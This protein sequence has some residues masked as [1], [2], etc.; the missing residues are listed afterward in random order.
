M[1][2]PD[3]CGHHAVA[4]TFSATVLSL[5]RLGTGSGSPA[6][7][8]PVFSAPDSHF[9]GPIHLP[10]PWIFRPTGKRRTRRDQQT[11]VYSSIP[12]SNDYQRHET[13]Q[14]LRN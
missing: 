7:A 8:R 12:S 6:H 4:T 10:N 11:V 14:N 13:A 3:H 1:A 5:K 2:R 9:P